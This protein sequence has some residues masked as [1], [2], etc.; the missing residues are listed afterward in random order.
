[1]PVRTTDG[2]R[3]ADVAQFQVAQAVDDPCHKT[4]AVPVKAEDFRKLYQ[5]VL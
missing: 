5:E 3:H 4:N 1:M 2:D